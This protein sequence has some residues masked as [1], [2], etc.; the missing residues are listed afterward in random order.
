MEMTNTEA[1]VE[2]E[3]LMAVVVDPMRSH[4]FVYCDN[5]F[6]QCWDRGPAPTSHNCF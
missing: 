6:S 2:V 3:A 1:V 4:L 5:T